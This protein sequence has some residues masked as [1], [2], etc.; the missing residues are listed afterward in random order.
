MNIKNIFLFIFSFFAAIVLMSFNSIA[1]AATPILTV[2]STGN[3]DL[4]RITVNG[5]ANSTVLLYYTKTGSGLQISSMGTTDSTGYFSNTIST[6]TYGMASSSAVYVAVNGQQS[7]STAWPYTTSSTTLSLSQTG[8]VLSVGQSST[9]TAGSSSL[10]LSNNSNA[11]IANVSI[12]GS[13]ITITAN[14]YGSTVV[15][16]C[17]Q[18]STTN[19]GS[20]Y[21]TVQSSG[22]SAITFSQTNVTIAA[23]QT[24]PI[25]I[26]GGTGTYSILSNSNAG[27]IQAS[28]TG[29]ILYLSTLNSN[30]SSTITVC[31]SGQSYCGIVN[32]TIGTASYTTLVFSP[33]SPTVAIGQNTTV[34][35]SGGS[36]STYYLSSNSNPSYVQASVNGSTLNL[37]G[38][39]NGTSI[40]TV[41]SSVGNCSSLSIIVNYVASGGNIALSQ[42]SLTLLTGQALT[43]TVS[44][45][46]APYSLASYQ[47]NVFQANISGNIVTITGVS[48]GSSSL[49][50]CSAEGGC[51]NLAI[52]V[53][54]NGTSS[55]SIILSQSSLS[56]TT[57]QSSTVYITGGGSYYISNNSSSSI[58]SAAISGSAV[59][60][61][62]LNAGSTNIYVCQTSG[63][64]A[65]LYVTVSSTGSTSTSTISSAFLT[66]SQNN[67]TIAIGQNSII[68]LSGGVSNYYVT[69]NSSSSVAST[70]V[71]GN[72][73]TI[74][75]LANGVA[76]I[77]VC[78]SNNACVPISVSVGSVSTNNTNN[79]SIILSPNNVSLK[80]GEGVLVSITGGSNYYISNNSSSNI[81]SAAIVGNKAIVAGIGTGTANVYI[82]QTGGQCATLVVSVVPK[83]S[84]IT[85]N[86]SNSTSFKFTKLL[87]VGLTGDDEVLELQKRLAEEGYFEGLPIGTFGPMTRVAVMAYQKAKGIRQTGNV[88][89]A[90][91]AALNNE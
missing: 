18:G 80:S 59:T 15:T 24:V 39:A 62:A 91:R 11:P 3:G 46:S 13:S 77:V 90:T 74:S 57:G 76:V 52:V 82:C 72:N 68:T 61:S 75:G 25:S 34:S 19:C 58:A 6:G 23:G 56:L 14:S 87:Y 29:S 28:I 21:V 38:I 66:A 43:V 22:A 8:V 84:S 37:Y 32:V 33:A 50:V 73:L 65:T 47:G 49:A 31:S 78:S 4:V 79:N 7:I 55:S 81:A 2:A 44:G 20:I 36:G 10:Y 54:G 26:S 64:C 42:S 35:I 83:S 86:S 17:S 70:S 85:S 88:G 60:V 41:C 5:D 71:S 9:I 48:V 51:I 12:S 30:G 89:D 27:V 16:I 40:V 69:Y 53:N 67:P 63:S 1:L 45:G